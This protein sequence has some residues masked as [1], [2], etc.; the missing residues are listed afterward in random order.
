MVGLV[1]GGIDPGGSQVAK[2]GGS[3]GKP[4]LEETLEKT[5]GEEVRG[6]RQ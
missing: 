3:G 5:G 1:E 2:K 4:P 6:L